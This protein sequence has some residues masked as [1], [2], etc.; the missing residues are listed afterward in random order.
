[1][2]LVSKISNL[3][4]PELKVNFLIHQRHRRTD[5]NGRHAISIPRYALVHR[6]LITI[7]GKLEVK[8]FSLI[9]AV[10]QCSNKRRVSIERQTIDACVFVRYEWLH[11]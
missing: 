2:Q 8:T 1:M 5:R 7:E 6:T 10:G 11:L 9:N 4:D 3:C